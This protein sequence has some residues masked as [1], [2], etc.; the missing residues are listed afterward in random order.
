MYECSGVDN[1]HRNPEGASW[2]KEITIV[3]TLKMGAVRSC[4]T[5]V[6]IYQTERCHFQGC[7]GLFMTRFGRYSAAYNLKYSAD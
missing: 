4:E 6:N 1:R 7:R 5:S 2:S 3:S